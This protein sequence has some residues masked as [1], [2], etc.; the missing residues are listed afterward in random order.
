MENTIKRHYYIDVFRGIAFFLMAIDHLF[1]DIVA[2]FSNYWD[3]YFPSTHYLNSVVELLK[4]YRQSDISGIIRFIFIAFV[5]ISISGVSSIFSKNNTKRGL[6]LFIIS[7]VLSLV[8]IILSLIIS[9]K[10]VIIY[11]GILHLISVC[12]LL[13]NIFRKINKYVLFVIA[14]L[15]IGLG[16][17]FDGLIVSTSLLIPFNI[18]PGFFVTADYYPI[19]PYMGFY[20]LGM[21]AGDWYFNILKKPKYSK[22]YNNNIFT[23]FGQNTLIWYFL[24]QVIIVV[25][26]VLFTLINL[27]FI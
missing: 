1:Y 19:L 13:T 26:L 5:F 8:T 15:I 25:F 23:Y 16:I 27:I 18:K 9:D 4:N 2:L 6:R 14:I 17:Y 20:I 10:S 12:M 7:I 11:F 22:N 24:H 3:R 21:L